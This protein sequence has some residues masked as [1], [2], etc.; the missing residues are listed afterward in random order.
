MKKMTKPS[1]AVLA[2]VGLL[3]VTVTTAHSSDLIISGVIDGPLTGGLPKAVEFYVVND[4]PDLSLYGFGG[5]NRIGTSESP[6][7]LKLPSYRNNDEKVTIA[8]TIVA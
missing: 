4:I 3:L 6:L 2:L 1:V 7:T 8:M 5:A